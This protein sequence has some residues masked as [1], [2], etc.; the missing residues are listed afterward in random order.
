MDMATKVLQAGPHLLPSSSLTKKIPLLPA[1]LKDNDHQ[2]PHF[3]YN[4]I[5]ALS[6]IGLE[7]VYVSIYESNTSDNTASWVHGAALPAGSPWC[8]V[9]NARTWVCEV[10]TGRESG[11][12]NVELRMLR[13]RQGTTYPRPDIAWRLQNCWVH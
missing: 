6:I 9:N 3:I 2:L 13:A 4:L 10:L 8:T 5:Q 1:N 7:R 11:D 12:F